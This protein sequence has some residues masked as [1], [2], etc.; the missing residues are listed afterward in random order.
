MFVK[1]SV[2]LHFGH[3]NTKRSALELNE[4]IAC[5]LQLVQSSVDLHCR[6]TYGQRVLHARHVF[7]EQGVFMFLIVYILL[8]DTRFDDLTVNTTNL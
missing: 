2:S 5:S 7:N 8:C 3:T 1:G 6:T 4:R